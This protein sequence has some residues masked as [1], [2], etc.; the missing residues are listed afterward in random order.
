[1]LDPVC[2]G[3]EHSPHAVGVL[4]H[5]PLVIVYIMCKLPPLPENFD[6]AFDDVTLSAPLSRDP[7]SF[8]EPEPE[9]S[10]R[11][12]RWASKAWILSAASTP[13]ATAIVTLQSSSIAS[14]DNQNTS[15]PAR[16]YRCNPQAPHLSWMC[17]I[18]S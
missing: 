1:M 6:S 8:F 9:D 4:V 3:L 2:S 14:L 13:H 15:P 10:M 7:I 16:S 17:T 11:V 18:K 5:Y 12:L